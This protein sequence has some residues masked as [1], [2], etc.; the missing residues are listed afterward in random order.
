MLGVATSNLAIHRGARVHDDFGAIERLMSTRDDDDVKC[1]ESK[2]LFANKT[3][4]VS[5]GG[6]PRSEQNRT[7]KNRVS[8][9]GSQ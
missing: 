4:L 8:Q 5:M 9:N 1:M 2:W 6:N 3:L 7:A